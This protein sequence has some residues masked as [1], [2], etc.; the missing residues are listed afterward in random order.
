MK[1][2]KSVAIIITMCIVFNACEEPVKF[3]E[4]QPT[5]KG[6]LSGFPNRIKG[7]YKSIN[8]DYTIEVSDKMIVQKMSGDVSI[9]KAEV[10]TSHELAL[11]G[12]LLIDSG[13]KISFKV[14]LINDT[15]RGTINQSDTIFN[16]V[17]GNVLRKYN[18]HYFINTKYDDGSYGVMMLTY[19]RGGHLTVSQIKKE[20]IDNL[21]TI[22]EIEEPNDST[23][24][25]DYQFTPTKKEFKKFV[26][27]MH[28]FRDEEEYLRVK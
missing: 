21:K 16:L 15:L 27:E 20:E 22:T 25:S 9:P 6:N 17:N 11:K 19:Q 26:S 4:P 2:L 23:F 28:G 13:N 3:S 18:G 14:N 12:D 8:D 5:G 24:T 1:N 10:D 7:V